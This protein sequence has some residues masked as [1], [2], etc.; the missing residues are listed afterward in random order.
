MC[1]WLQSASSA[2]HLRLKCWQVWSHPLPSLIDVEQCRQSMVH[3]HDLWRYADTGY[4][5][6]GMVVRYGFSEYPVLLA[7]FHLFMHVLV[8]GLFLKGTVDVIYLL[9]ISFKK[10]I[11][12]AKIVPCPTSEG[13]WCVCV[14]VCVCVCDGPWSFI[15]W[16]Y[17]L[18]S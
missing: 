7:K 13:S 15:S 9:S 12:Y 17:V 6:L 10:G 14:C 11:C 18:R 2:C 4:V 16:D 3:V 5:V 1:L 8:H